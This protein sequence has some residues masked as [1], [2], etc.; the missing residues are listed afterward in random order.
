VSE[1]GRTIYSNGFGY[2]DVENMQH[3]HPHTV[4]RI[5]SIS[6]PIA[7][8]IAAKLCESGKL[9]LDK[10]IDFYLKDLPKFKSDNREYQITTRHLISHTSG[11]RHYEKKRDQATSKEYKVKRDADLSEFYSAKNYK[12]TKEALQVFINDEL[13]FQPGTFNG[14]FVKC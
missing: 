10:P 3:A 12:D 6:K 11:I 4:M 1:N 8:T 5:A 13:M 14:R 7:C 2:C 9:D